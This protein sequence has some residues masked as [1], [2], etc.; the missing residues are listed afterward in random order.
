V[1]NPFAFSNVSGK[2]LAAGHLDTVY[3]FSL[4][5]DP[6]LS[7]KRETLQISSRYL[8]SGQLFKIDVKDKPLMSVI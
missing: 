7:A 4:S 1:L 6:F 3:V 8:S 2:H 5:D